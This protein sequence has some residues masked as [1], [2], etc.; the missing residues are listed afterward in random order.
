MDLQTQV[1]W[2]GKGIVPNLR[3]PS[4]HSDPNIALFLQIPLIFH[5]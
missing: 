5:I 1:P 4:G 3:L 2:T